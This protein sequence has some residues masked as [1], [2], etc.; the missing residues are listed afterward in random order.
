MFYLCAIGVDSISSYAG[1]TA[2]NPMNGSILGLFYRELY[3][4]DLMYVVSNRASK[5]LDI[6][7]FKQYISNFCRYSKG[8]ELITISIHFKSIFIFLKCYAFFPDCLVLFYYLII[9]IHM[10]MADN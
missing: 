3:Y 8:K 2:S 10:T 9:R 1:L 7:I 5:T 6:S 4:L